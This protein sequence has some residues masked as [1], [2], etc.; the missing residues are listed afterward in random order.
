MNPLDLPGPEFLGLYFVL[1]VAAVAAAFFLRWFLRLPG[2]EPSREA[3]DLSPYEVAY[4]AG[5]EELAVNAALA[6]LVHED[7]LAVD[8]I[9]R[10]LTRQ[11]DEP[12]GDARKLERAV[13]SAVN[14][15]SGETIANV[16]SD[17]ARAF[18]SIQR[19]LQDL[20]LLVSEDRSWQARL[21]P[22]FV[23][24]SVVFFGVL[25][26]FVGLSR[27]R[28][29]IFL[30]IFCI[31][32]VVVAFVGF[33]RAVR[34][35]RRGDRALDRLRKSN[36]ALEYS[37]RFRADDLAGDDL[38]LAVGLFGMGVLAG[39]ALAKLQTALKPPHTPV[40]SG[41]CGSSGCGGGGG[42]ACGGG[43]GGCG[44][45]CGGCGG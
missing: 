31:I 20:E 41:G 37:R 12:P 27:D 18:G 6:R 34:R 16:R 40:S 35:S 8:A 21:I 23:V 38:A 45:G 9:N 44:G 28:P 36:A 42:G 19:R 43:G 33:G 15:E 1:F 32:S 25:K 24:L 14:G 39:G 7:V 4:L 29:V 22:L 10:R 3:L 13:F 5:G 17:A 26:I 30:V 2:D 11:S